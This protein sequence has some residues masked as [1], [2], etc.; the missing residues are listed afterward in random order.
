MRTVRRSCMTAGVGLCRA[1][2]RF[3]RCTSLV[4]ASII[5]NRE[6]ALAFLQ[7][8]KKFSKNFSTYKIQKFHCVIFLC[9]FPLS[10]RAGRYCRPGRDGFRIA[11]VTGTAG[12]FPRSGGGV[13]Q[14]S[15]GLYASSEGSLCPFTAVTTDDFQFHRGN[16]PRIKRE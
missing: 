13:V 15:W 12:P 9:A 10:K 7:N 2:S 8:K 1:M 14:R 5:I 11:H 16:S 3:S 6:P 4:R